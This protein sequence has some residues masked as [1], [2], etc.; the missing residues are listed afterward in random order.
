GAA[1]KWAY[2]VK[3]TPDGNAEII[4]CANNF[5]GRTVTVV[6][7]STEPLY[8]D[9]YGPYTPGFKVIPYGDSGALTKAINANTA[10]FLAEPIQGEAGVLVPPEGFLRDARRI[11]SDS[12]VLF[13]LDEIQTGF[14]RTGRKFCY[15]Y[16]GIK[17]DGIALGK[18]L[19]GGILPVAAFA[20]AKELLGVFE[21]GEHGSTFGGNPLSCAVARA[22]LKVLD[23]EHL[24]ER[25][26]EMG[27]YLSEG[28]KRIRSRWVK[29]VRG[30]GL[31]IGIELFKEAGGARRF[32]EDLM[33]KGILCK[34]THDDVI[35]VAP[36]LV[37]DKSTIDW[38]L[39]RFED[40]L[41]A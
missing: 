11:C 15:E 2:K 31:L 32:C 40:V 25:A 1:R 12:G 7:F 10:A 36:P 30:K 4:V 6:S 33:K 26:F 34:E 5:H 37:I 41:T 3:G 24:A 39:E 38:A 14:G 9:H 27:S 17:P 20:G 18:A 19:G 23:D 16:E 29:E 13:I 28:L 8:K 35:R 21:P 22:A